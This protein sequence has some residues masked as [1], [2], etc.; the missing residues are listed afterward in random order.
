M[1]APLD[2][3]NRKPRASYQKDW[4]DVVNSFSTMSSRSSIDDFCKNKL[5]LQRGAEIV[6][7]DGR[8]RSEY[9]I[10]KC[11]VRGGNEAQTVESWRPLCLIKFTQKT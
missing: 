2:G 10:Y 5:P 11:D 8:A 7:P 1:D 9:I 3:L 4:H 6:A